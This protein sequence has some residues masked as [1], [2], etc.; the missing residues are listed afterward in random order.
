MWEWL[1]E[2]ASVIATVGVTVV[3]AAVTVMFLGEV[4]I[5]HREDW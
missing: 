4:M 1:R 2:A 5:K 3:V